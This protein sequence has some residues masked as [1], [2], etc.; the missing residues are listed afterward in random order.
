MGS[1]S[2]RLSRHNTIA[3]IGRF[4]LMAAA[5]V[6]LTAPG[7]SDDQKPDK[8]VT[9]AQVMC[10]WGFYLRAQII[11]AH[12]GFARKP[13]D[14]A[15]DDAV[16]EIEEFA[17]AHFPPEYITR[18]KP[19][20]ARRIAKETPL[21]DPAHKKNLCEEGGSASFLKDIRDRDPD[22]FRKEVKELLSRPLGP[23]GG[24]FLCHS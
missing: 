5:T 15:I 19:E 4:T 13:I 8:A 18:P 1:S 11:T 20:D 9:P 2:A 12:C 6:A 7:L 10:V 21:F 3:F 17:L 22:Q 16:A 14:D 24:I 23:P